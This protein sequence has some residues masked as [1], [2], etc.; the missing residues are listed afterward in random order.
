M[1]KA[2]V[3]PALAILLCLGITGC[4]NTPVTGTA[5]TVSVDQNAAR[6]AQA[7]QFATSQ[8]VTLA[9]SVYAA[10]GHGPEAL[11]IATKI[12]GLVT[13][14][15]LPYLDGASGASS[16][17]V[18]GFIGSQFVTLPAQAQGF[19]SLAAAV[20]DTYLPAPSANAV[21][22]ATQLL[23]VKAFFNGLNDGAS[24]FSLN[25]P[26]AVPAKPAAGAKDVTPGAW[27]NVVKK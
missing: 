13:A 27:F 3:V 15:A 12:K 10:E 1:K 19:I 2:F 4:G 24:Q 23:Y 5:P 22:D 18:N 8:S 25:S 14:T 16:A 21:M 7:I 9:L 11:D 17:A 20:L 26:N 6:N